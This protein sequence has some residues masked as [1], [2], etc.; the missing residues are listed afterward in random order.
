[1]DGATALVARIVEASAR[2]RAVKAAAQGFGTAVFTHDQLDCGTAEP[3]RLLATAQADGD[4]HPDINVDDIF[5]LPNTAPLDQP[6]EVRARRLA[7]VLPG[8]LR[9][10]A[11]GTDIGGR[12]AA[13]CRGCPDQSK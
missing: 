13:A 11:L 4:L 9:A 8:F 7:L 5:L 3:S 12:A 1:M 10:P 6:P 2:D